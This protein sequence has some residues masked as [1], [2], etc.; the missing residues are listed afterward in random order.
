MV[1]VVARYN[2]NIDWLK[3]TALNYIIFNKGEANLPLWVKNEIKL[4]NIGRE[5]HTYLTYIILNYDNLP[6]HSVFVQGN[7]F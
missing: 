1:L 7:P 2:E 4:P 3:N 6:E 5:A